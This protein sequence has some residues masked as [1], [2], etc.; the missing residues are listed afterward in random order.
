MQDLH[1]RG[2]LRDNDPSPSL[3]IIFDNFGGQNKNNVV[4]KMPAYLV[5]RGGL[6]GSEHFVLCQWALKNKWDWLLNQLNLR[7]H[8]PNIYTIKTVFQVLD[9]QPNATGIGTD[10]TS[11]FKYDEALDKLYPKL[12]AGTIKK[13]TYSM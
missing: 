13:I 1:S 3:K 6:Y 10:S 7:Y 11:F 8:K 2:W 12:D 9:L 5:E 4:L